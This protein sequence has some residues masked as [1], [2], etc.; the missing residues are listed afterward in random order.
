MC[1]WGILLKISFV[2]KPKQGN[3]QQS[4]FEKML[5]MEYSCPG[6]GEVLL[7][8]GVITALTPILDTRKKSN[9]K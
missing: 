4:R 8:V 9:H 3:K 2:D 6:I 7:M 1:R 5:G